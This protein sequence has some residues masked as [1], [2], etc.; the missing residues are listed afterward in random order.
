MGRNDPEKL[1]ARMEAKK[2]LGQHKLAIKNRL[3]VYKPYH[4]MW[5]GEMRRDEATRQCTDRWDLVAE[6]ADRL[7]ATSLL[8]LGC[9]DGFFVRM[10]GE[11]GLF[12]IGVDYEYRTLT[13]VEGVRMF[14]KSENSGFVLA[15]IDKPFVEKLPKFD[16]VLFF[17]VM[18]HIWRQFPHEYGLELLRAIRQRTNKVLFFDTGQSNETSTTW[19]AKVPDMGPDPREWLTGYLRQAGFPRVDVVG[20]T[21]AFRGENRRYLF[22]CEVD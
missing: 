1:S 9:A 19:A 22:R 4:P 18:H 20:E 2:L 17:S 21:D 5:M 16:V 15:M 7:S 10:A 6:A 13:L 14:D 8:D 12:S 11:K 3:S